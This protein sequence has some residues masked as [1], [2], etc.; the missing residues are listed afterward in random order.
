MRWL[1]GL[2]VLIVAGVATLA[3]AQ[4]AIVALEASAFDALL[5]LRH[6]VYG[7]PFRRQRSHAVVI[8]LDQETALRP[9]FDRLPVSLW[10]PQLAKV[11]AAVLDS[12]A[13]VIGQQAFTTSA[14]AAL[15][16][17]DADY[18]AVLARAAAEDR[19]VL[20]RN[21]PG[22]DRLSPFPGHVEAVGGYRNVRRDEL[23]ADADGVIRQ[24]ALFHETLATNGSAGIQPSLAL[25]LAARV[26]NERP[27][28]VAGRNVV[29]GQYQVPKS[30]EAAMLMNP[31]GG[32][33]GVPVFSLADLYACAEAGDEA[34]F[35]KYFEG[36]VVIVGRLGPAE[37][38]HRTAARLLGVKDE[39]REARRCRLSPMRSL[40]ALSAKSDTPDPVIIATAVNNLLRE[41]AINRSAAPFGIVIAGLLALAAA[42]LGLRVRF[43]LAL[44]ISAAFLGGWLYLATLT[45]A[46]Q[47]WLMPL[48]QPLSAFLL[49]LIIAWGFGLLRPRLRR[50]RATA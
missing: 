34:F 27:Q 17:Y 30:S 50:G 13:D 23:T 48:V 16:D 9:P 26:L 7:Q 39:D 8:A 12:G 35:R 14:A 29:L 31:Q 10:T 43:L 6:Q 2:A 32:D 11:M 1:D 18:R 19:I 21:A 40:K 3:V 46:K 24:M 28:I 25:E 22:P 49:S 5:A 45:L 37:T 47:A 38:R 36:K 33:G 44:P 41:N 42:I 4:P 15:P 20:G